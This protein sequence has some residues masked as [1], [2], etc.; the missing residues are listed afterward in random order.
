MNLSTRMRKAIWGVGACILSYAGT[1]HAQRPQVELV[2]QRGHTEAVTAV[3][4]SPD[5][6]LVAT[7]GSP[8]VVILWDP[9]TG[10]ELKRLQGTRE[11]PKSIVFSPDSKLLYV[12]GSELNDVQVWNIDSGKIVLRLNSDFGNE[13]ESNFEDKYAAT[14]VYS[15]LVDCLSLSEDGKVVVLG[16]WDGAILLD[17]VTGKEIAEFTLNEPNPAVPGEFT[18]IPLN[19][20]LLSPD[21]HWL[22]GGDSH[23]VWIWDV[24]KHGQGRAIRI[25]HNGSERPFVVSGVFGASSNATLLAVEILGNGPAPAAPAAV[26]EV[27]V[28][29]GAVL[30]AVWRS[31]A[32]INLTSLGVSDNR[33]TLFV[34]SMPARSLPAL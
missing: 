26:L 32:S 12:L 21:R 1:A 8:D 17:A 4:Y 22:I 14:K 23:Q 19:Y 2:V 31:D 10:A 30:R 28:R 29:T 5:G 27:D 11:E 33:K 24:A 20:A 18:S 34:G 13:L 6:R 25:P 7:G 9:T 16:I 15:S 3:A